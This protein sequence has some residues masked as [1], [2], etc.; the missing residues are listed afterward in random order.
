MTAT[1]RSLRKQWPR[2]VLDD[3]LELQSEAEVLADAAKAAEARLHHAREVLS[4]RSEVGRQKY[5]E[6]EAAFERSIYQPAILARQKASVA[7]QIFVNVRGWLEKLP[8]NTRLGKVEP[9]PHRYKLD[10]ALRER[11]ELLEQLKQLRN[12]PMPSPDIKARVERRVQ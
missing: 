12:A 3:L 7:G 5:L 9:L 11:A 8:A 1:A 10:G 6:V 4:G 2:H